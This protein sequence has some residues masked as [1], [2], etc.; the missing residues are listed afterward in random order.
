[1]TPINIPR[2]MRSTVSRETGDDADM[3]SP[4][5]NSQLATTRLEPASLKPFRVTVID[6]HRKRTRDL[7]FA[8]RRCREKVHKPGQTPAA[9]SEPRPIRRDSGRV[10]MLGRD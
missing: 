4:H 1:M 5:E 8:L 7:A 10:I 2:N 3:A 9:V 6:R